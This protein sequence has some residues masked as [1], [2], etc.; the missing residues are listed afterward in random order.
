MAPRASA[1]LLAAAT[2]GFLACVG[3]GGEREAALPAEPVGPLVLTPAQ[4]PA[5]DALV[6][7]AVFPTIGR[8]AVSGLQS[9]RGA[10]LAVEEL[11]REGGVHGRPLHLAA[12]RTG[13]YFVDA[14]HAAALAARAGALAIVGSNSS[15]LS[16]AVAEEAERS[17]VVQVT[18]VSTAADLTWDPVAKRGRPFVFRMC[19]TDDVMGELLAGFAREELRAK[20][21]AV[22]YEVG[23]PYSLRLARSFVS[24]FSD[25]VAGHV[26]AEFFYLALETDFRPQLQRI[27]EFSPDVLFLPGSFPDATLVAAQ[28]GPLGLRTTLLGAD[29]WSSPLLF[30]K[31]GPPGEAYY[32]ELCSPAP[33]FDRHDEGEESPEPPGCRAVLAYDAVRVIAA[34]LRSLGRLP[35]EAT[36]ASLAETRRRLRDAVAGTEVVGATG[37]IRFDAHGDRRQGVALYAVEKSPLGPPRPVVRGW[38]GEP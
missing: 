17:G 2:L 24:R 7:A 20:R 36:G 15:E 5:G 34:G 25:D 12:Y 28:A 29:G 9:L 23:R 10:R 32:L 13:S 35:G 18:N 19:A 3:A 1:L 6:V 11:N 4:V 16:Q 33:E 21:A 38:L 27:R 30:A 22:L 14:G 31:G 37:R 8:Y 26:V